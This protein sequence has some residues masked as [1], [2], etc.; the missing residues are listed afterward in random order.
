[1]KS[2]RDHY[3][4]RISTAADAVQIVK[5][6]DRIVFSHACGEPRVLPG[7]LI[8][9]AEE[10]R[11]VEIVHMVPMGDALYCQPGY[12]L[13]FRHVAFFAGKPTREAIWENR[14]D[15]IPCLFSQ[16]PSLFES[17]LPIDIAMI[18]VSPPDDSGFCSL[19][20][21]V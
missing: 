3:Q 2:W 16:V 17:T 10:L 18:T 14:A 1:M 11:N 6:G 9:R 20:V 5:S 21:S 7:E 19:G 15:Y 8:K 12:A 13:S 4:A